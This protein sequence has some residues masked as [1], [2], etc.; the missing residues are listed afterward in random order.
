MKRAR[1][2]VRA[3]EAP[4]PNC[5]LSGMLKNQT[6]ESKLKM[7]RHL[8]TLRPKE[9]K[10]NY[11]SDE[12]STELFCLRNEY[13]IRIIIKKQTCCD[14]GLKQHTF[15]PEDTNT[16]NLLFRQISVSFSF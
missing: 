1:S 7:Y 5:L 16:L 13:L 2:K 9:I 4:F 14:Q 3:F 8:N 12:R 11:K 15:Y 10:F 6:R